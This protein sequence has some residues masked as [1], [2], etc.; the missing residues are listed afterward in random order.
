[1]FLFSQFELLVVSAEESSRSRRRGWITL[2]E[3]LHQ[4]PSGWKSQNLFLIHS[5]HPS[6]VNWDTLLIIAVELK[7]REQP[8][9]WTLPATMSKGKMGLALAVSR[10]CRF[11]LTAHY[12]EQVPWPQVTKSE[13]WSALLL[14]ARKGSTRKCWRTASMPI[15]EVASLSAY[16]VLAVCLVTYVI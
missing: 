11:L 8:S 2:Q 3:H 12:L 5:T 16:Y 6:W 7:L 15:K 13:A 14:C 10:I 1:M 4:N 9:S